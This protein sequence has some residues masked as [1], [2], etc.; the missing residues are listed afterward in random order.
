MTGA[1]AAS[2][3]TSLHG[4]SVASL[5]KFLSDMA[6]GLHAQLRKVYPMPS[7]VAA[8]TLAANVSGAHRAVL[9]LAQAL[10]EGAGDGR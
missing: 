1:L 7:V 5:L 3:Y 2:A 8:E 10:R 6:A 9:R 4:T